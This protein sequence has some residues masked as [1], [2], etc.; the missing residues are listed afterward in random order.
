MAP[1]VDEKYREEINK[2]RIELE[3][4]V[5]SKEFSAPDFLRLAYASQ[6]TIAN[7]H[8]DDNA[9]N[10]TSTDDATKKKTQS[11]NNNSLKTI[12]KI[13]AN[14]PI[15]TYPDLYQLAGIVAVK[16]LGGLDIEFVPGRTESLISPD[17]SSLPDVK[18]SPA[19]LR[20]VFR[21]VEISDP[22]HIVALYGG[23]KLA[24]AGA[25]GANLK[26]DNS[27]FVD[28]VDK[29]KD[30]SPA[31]KALLD[32]PEFH[33]CVRCYAMH[34]EDFFEDYEEAHK[35]LADLGLPYSAFIKSKLEKSASQVK[36]VLGA[37]KAV[38]VGVAVAAAVVILSFFYVINR[39]T[40]KHSPHQFQ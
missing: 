22:K 11:P 17:E 39:R 9:G 21:K 29:K 35:K 10:T 28:L 15:I 14:H 13:K 6:F 16:E 34:K 36:K 38:G 2:A 12:A 37:Q 31:E 33:N 26:L 27:Y 18:Q 1:R 8:H 40:A 5:K 3:N 7:S 32:D 4:L 30:L 19:E 25:Q 24:T 23:L 20:D